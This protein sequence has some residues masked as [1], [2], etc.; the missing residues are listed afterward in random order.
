MKSCEER[1]LKIKLERNV[2]ELSKLL[3]SYP[4]PSKIYFFMQVF[5]TLYSKADFGPSLSNHTI[6]PK[7]GHKVPQVHDAHDWGAW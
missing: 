1:K 3:S 2:E 4:I 5:T 6:P 7:Q